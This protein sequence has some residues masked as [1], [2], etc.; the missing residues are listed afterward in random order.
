MAPISIKSSSSV[1]VTSI[2]WNQS[3]TLPMTYANPSPHAA[4]GVKSDNAPRIYGSAL[5]SHAHSLARRT[6]RRLLLGHPP[7]TTALKSKPLPIQYPALSAAPR[8]HRH[9]GTQKRCGRCRLWVSFTPL[10]LSWLSGEQEGRTGAALIALP[11][12][13]PP[14]AVV[15]V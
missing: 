5:A 3:S 2:A 14:S 9:M 10:P 15:R 7:L 1:R 8:V 13:H 12:A 4:G 11:G 6:R